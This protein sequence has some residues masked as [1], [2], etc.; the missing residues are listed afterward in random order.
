MVGGHP[1]VIDGAPTVRIIAFFEKALRRVPGVS[2]LHHY[3]LVESVSESNL[4]KTGSRSPTTRV[5]SGFACSLIA[6]MRR[7]MEQWCANVAG[8]QPAD[9]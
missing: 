1:T 4:T 8:R 9:H 6:G 7:L 2:P 5:L 3:S